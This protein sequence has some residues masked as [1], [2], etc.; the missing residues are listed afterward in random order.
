MAVP[1][2]YIIAGLPDILFNEQKVDIRLHTF[3]KELRD[4]IPPEDASLLSYVGY[5]ID[6]RNLLI[7]LL[8][9]NDPILQFGNFTEEELEEEIRS[10]DQ[11][12]EYMQEY[13]AAYNDN[14][15]I[16][17][18]LSWENQLYWLFFEHTSFLENR[19]L[20]EW[21]T[22]ELHLRNILTAIKCRSSKM[23][24]DSHILCR[25][26]VTALIFK[27]SAPDFTLPSKVHWADD[28]FA[29]DFY[30]IPASEEKLV[31]FRLQQLEDLA[32]PE[33]FSIET[34]IQAGIALSLAERWDLLDAPAGKQKLEKIINDLESR[35]QAE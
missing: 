31:R 15:T 18:N 35:Y 4:Q 24:F 16:I 11:L 19:F 27:S 29:I 8:N 23:P 5:P 22:F 6:N 28:L 21:F 1:Y 17:Q 7:K 10:P 3:I 13:L 26:E 30:S 34:I 33:L 2:Q 25:N 12:P 9:K 32:E 14:T 20:N